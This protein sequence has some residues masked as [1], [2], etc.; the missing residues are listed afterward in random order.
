[1]G[2]WY[3]IG[4]S[5]GLGAALAVFVSGLAGFFRTFRGHYLVRAFAL[6][7]LGALVGIEI[8][9]WQPGGWLDV[10]AGAVAASLVFLGAV[11]IV[12]GAFRRGGTR[13]G[14]AVLMTGMALIAAGIA[15]IPAAGFLEGVAIPALALRL[16]RTQPER[17]AGLRTLAKD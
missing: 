6:L 4:V 3:W 8:H 1:M 13:F 17:Y 16:R 15:F 12:D 10:V 2:A 14:L 7:W 11:V 5:A 9:L